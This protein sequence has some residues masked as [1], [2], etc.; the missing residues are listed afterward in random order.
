MQSVVQK[1][2]V[3]YEKIENM[4]RNRKNRQRDELVQNNHNKT[5][6]CQHSIVMHKQSLEA[7]N[8]T[9]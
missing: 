9:E 4:K 3:K 1:E 5:T 6:F 8:G 7:I 2:Y